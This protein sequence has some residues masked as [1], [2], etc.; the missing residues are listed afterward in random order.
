MLLYV[1]GVR[2]YINAPIYNNNKFFLFK[3]NSHNPEAKAIK[4]ETNEGDSKVNGEPNTE[5]ALSPTTFNLIRSPDK[6][7]IKNFLSGGRSCRSKPLM[8]RSIAITFQ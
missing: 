7:N 1:V 2:S 6:E 4:V 8:Q 5:E 3:M